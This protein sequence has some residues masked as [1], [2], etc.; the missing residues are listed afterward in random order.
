MRF[1]CG[2]PRSGT[3]YLLKHLNTADDTICFGESLFFGRNFV[4]PEISGQFYSDRQLNKIKEIYSNYGWIGASETNRSKEI[5]DKFEEAIEKYYG[6]GSGTP[7]QIFSCLVSS[8]SWVH[9]C[10]NVIEKTP[11][12]IHFISRI[13]NYF[14]EA[15][16]VVLKREFTEFLKSY[17]YQGSQFSDPRIRRSF[18]LKY[19][20]AIS[21]MIY[22]KYIR[23]IENFV[24]LDSVLIIDNKEINLKLSDIYRHFNLKF[25]N[26]TLGEKVNSSYNTPLGGLKG[27]Q[28]KYV[29]TREDEIWSILLIEG[30][31]G[32]MSLFD[33]L[34]LLKSILTLPFKCLVWCFSTGMDRRALI[35]YIRHYLN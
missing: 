13:M 30:E 2:M 15:K 33:T 17:K 35:R 9:E 19:H 21:C 24:D 28:S 12:H 6:T 25:N 29:L 27:G 32:Q 1:I 34:I 11:H 3:T 14:P 4:F 5:S 31:N 18:R 8:I 26:T 7:K 20:P 22:R 10:S 16:F 23:S